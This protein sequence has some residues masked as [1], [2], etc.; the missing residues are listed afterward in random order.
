MTVSE[1]S[2]IERAIEKMQK[3]YA[4]V[5]TRQTFT[6]FGNIQNFISYI[7][8][9]YLNSSFIIQVCKNASIRTNYLPFYINKISLNLG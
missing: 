8:Y 9:S 5:V 3:D 1:T 6:N 4:N 2:R 7:D